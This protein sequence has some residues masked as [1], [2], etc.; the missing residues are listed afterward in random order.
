MNKSTASGAM[1]KNS[2]R[3]TSVKKSTRRVSTTEI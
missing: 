1:N 2:A 3:T